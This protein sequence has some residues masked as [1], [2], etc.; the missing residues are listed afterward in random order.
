LF[1][2]GAL[3]IFKVFIFVILKHEKNSFFVMSRNFVTN[4]QK[5]KLKVENLT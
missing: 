4:L 2:F 1:M 5:N 3:L